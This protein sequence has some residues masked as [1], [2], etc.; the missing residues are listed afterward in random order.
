M[1]LFGCA[2]NVAADRDSGDDE[3]RKPDNLRHVESEVLKCVVR[4]DVV[5]ANFRIWE[6]REEKNRPS[7]LILNETR[8]VVEV[9]PPENLIY[10]FELDDTL[11]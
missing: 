5:L 8:S 7:V 9:R 10:A 1:Q 4:D 2:A 3:A 11:A 6:T